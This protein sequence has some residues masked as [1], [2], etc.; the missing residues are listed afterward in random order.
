M[1][2]FYPSSEDSRAITKEYKECFI[3]LSAC[4]SSLRF[5]ILL[6][7]PQ[8]WINPPFW[9][10]QRCIYHSCILN[11]EINPGLTVKSKLYFCYQ[12][13]KCLYNEYFAMTSEICTLDT[14]N[15]ELKLTERARLN[16]HHTRRW[17]PCYTQGGNSCQSLRSIIA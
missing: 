15:N 11:I 17:W 8:K 6:S 7:Y 1:N 10:I 12:L 4:A 3:E 9:L 2:I 14:Q 16:M 13:F 5:Q